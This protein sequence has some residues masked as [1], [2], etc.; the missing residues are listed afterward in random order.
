MQALSATPTA[1]D[2]VV[3]AVGAPTAAV[4]ATLSEMEMDGIITRGT[5]GF[6]ALKS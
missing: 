1:I 5:G 2:D 6:V 3:Q 4:T